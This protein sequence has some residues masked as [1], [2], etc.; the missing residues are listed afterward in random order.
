MTLDANKRD[1]LKVAAL[2]LGSQATGALALPINVAGKP[3]APF[4]LPPLPYAL[5][6]LAPVVDAETMHLHHDRHHQAYVDNLNKALVANA[7]LQGL[8]LD[9]LIARPDLPASVHNNA[10]GHW[11]H[12]FF[13]KTMT[14]PGQGGAPSPALAAAITRKF[15]SLD[16]MKAALNAAGVAQ[17]GSGWAWLIVRKDGT[18][19]VAATP[20]QDNPLMPGAKVAGTPILGNDVWEHAYY[21]TYRNRRADYLAAWWQLVD[22]SEVSRRYAAAH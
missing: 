12:S 10:G 20:N 16:A 13:W 1:L 7:S 6:A 19:D 18:L 8:T 5:D 22:W 15:G 3:G 9:Q 17:F 21:L 14:K 2:V 11:N 4:T